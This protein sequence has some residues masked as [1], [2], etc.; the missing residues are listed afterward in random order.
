MTD[1]YAVIGNPVA[2][3]QSPHIHRMF[4]DA[5]GEDMEYGMVLGRPGR[6]ADDDTL[7]LLRCGPGR[8]PCRA[9]AQ[10]PPHHHSMRKGARK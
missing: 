7:S 3:S 9:A 4:A 2:H 6:F 5:L 8:P 10:P 1:R